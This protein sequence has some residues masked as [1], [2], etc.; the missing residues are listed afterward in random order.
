MQVL[1][2]KTRG[3]EPVAQ[4]QRRQERE[5][6]EDL[7]PRRAQRELMQVLSMKTHGPDPV[8][9]RSPSPRRPCQSGV[10]PKSPPHDVTEQSPRCHKS[11]AARRQTRDRG[12][13]SPTV[14]SCEESVEAADGGA[15]VEERHESHD[16]GLEAPQRTR[17]G[18]R[19]E[20]V[21]VE[22]ADAAGVLVLHPALVHHAAAGSGDVH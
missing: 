11:L 12:C 20:L 19:R 4:Q 22:A 5:G 18:R 7:A 6:A 21:A 10:F 1:Y 17:P 2:M 14:R 15:A 16:D 13:S 9:Q 3:P 8:A